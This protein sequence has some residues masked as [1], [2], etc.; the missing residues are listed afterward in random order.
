MGSCL[1]IFL[2]ISVLTGLSLI[3][4]DPV[5]H[6]NE[7]LNAISELI[8]IGL[9]ISLNKYFIGMTIFGVITMNISSKSNNS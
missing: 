3:I 8:E 1:N 9:N 6:A 4:F 2:A 7:K 5:T